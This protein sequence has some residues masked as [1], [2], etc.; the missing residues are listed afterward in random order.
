VENQLPVAGRDRVRHSLRIS[1]GQAAGV[2]GAADKESNYITITGMK[3][4]LL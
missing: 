4:I 1:A 3:I 2:L